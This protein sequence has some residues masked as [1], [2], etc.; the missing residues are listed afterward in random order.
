MSARKTLRRIAEILEELGITATIDTSSHHPK[1]C[2]CGPLGSRKVI[3]S[4]SPSDHRAMLNF[5]TD[6]RRIAREVGVLPS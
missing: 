5:R 2:I 4:S 1:V 3:A 6:L